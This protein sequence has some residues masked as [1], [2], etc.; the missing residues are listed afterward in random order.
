MIS[1]LMLGA[2]LNYLTRN[3]LSITYAASPMKA[4]LHMTD[5]EYSWVVNAFQGTLMLQPACGY[6]LDLIGL[7]AGMAIFVGS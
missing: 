2:I 1:L 4:D 3:T 6:L 5:R 7:K